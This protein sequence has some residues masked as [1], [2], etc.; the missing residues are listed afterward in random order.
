[1]ETFS[2]AYGTRRS[3]AGTVNPDPS[4]VASDTI[5]SRLTVGINQH[6]LIT[7]ENTHLHYDSGFSLYPMKMDLVSSAGETWTATSS[8][9]EIASVDLVSSPNNIIIKSTTGSLDK[10]GLSTIEIKSQ[11]SNGSAVVQGDYG[12]ANENWKGLPL[13][14]GTYTCDRQQSQE[15]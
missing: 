11:Y 14:E 9:R 13:V 6:V 5:P 2:H 10:K 1:M 3:S 4:N 15:K 8:N 12:Q 7:R